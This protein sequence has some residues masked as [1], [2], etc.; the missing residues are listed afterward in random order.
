[1]AWF[2]R[3]SAGSSC[4]EP[5]GEDPVHVVERRFRGRCGEAANRGVV[6]REMWR[7]RFETGDPPASKVG[8]TPRT[9]AHAAGHNTIPKAWVS[10]DGRFM[11][12]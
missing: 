2:T 6:D 1:M 5:G 9:R 8:A 3:S 12:G 11:I 7:D 10:A 4:A